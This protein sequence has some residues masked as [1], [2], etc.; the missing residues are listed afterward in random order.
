MGRIGTG[1]GAPEN[2]GRCGGEPL[3]PG[4]VADA[5]PAPEEPSPNSA[6]A[7][8]TMIA[9]R[10]AVEVAYQSVEPNLTGLEMDHPES[11]A[12]NTSHDNNGTPITARR[13]MLRLIGIR[14]DLGGWL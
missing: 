11:S 9:I 7:T 13:N 12:Q 6:H 10:S 3:P 14:D 5:G 8:N 1:H 2:G 4:T